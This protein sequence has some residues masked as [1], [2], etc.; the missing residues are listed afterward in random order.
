MFL[1]RIKNDSGRCSAYPSSFRPQ[2]VTFVAARSSPPDRFTRLLLSRPSSTSSA[3]RDRQQLQRHPARHM[4]LLAHLPDGASPR[5]PRQ[6]HLSHGGVIF[7][8]RALCPSVRGFWLLAQALQYA[9]GGYAGPASG[10]LRGGD[11]RNALVFLLHLL[12]PVLP[13]TASSAPAACAGFRRPRSCALIAVAFRSGDW[14]P[15]FRLSS[16]SPRCRRWRSSPDPC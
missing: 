5:Q 7:T 14:P 16:T 12:A 8:W 3:P 4:G 10:G 13:A 15:I 1:E 6:G 11:G 9:S 2:T